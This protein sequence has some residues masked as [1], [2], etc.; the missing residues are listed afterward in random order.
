MPADKFRIV[1]KD[2]HPLLIGMDKTLIADLMGDEGKVL[3]SRVV[4]EEILHFLHLG[5]RIV[6]C[7]GCVVEIALTPP[8][9]VLFNDRPVFENPAVWREIVELDRNPKECLGF[10]VL[11]QIGI[12]LTG[13]HDS[14]SEQ[15]AIT[16]FASGRWD[17]MQAQ[18]KSFNP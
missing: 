5:V 3:S 1:P 11:E 18:M 4:G 9:N 15:L 13:F 6:I 16:A 8:A 7:G 2:F 17:K 12:T 10:I 14:D